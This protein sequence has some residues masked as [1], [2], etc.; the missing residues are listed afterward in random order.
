MTP[1]TTPAEPVLHVRAASL[2]NY[3]AVA[4]EMGLDGPAMLREFGIDARLLQDPESKIAAASVNR[5]LTESA[6][7]SGNEAFGLL[8]AERR[9]FSSFG[10]LSLLLRHEA[11]L[12]EVIRRLQEYSPLLSKVAGFRLEEERDEEA[13]LVVEVAPEVANRQS[14]EMVMALTSDVLGGAMFGGWRPRE[15]YFRHRAPAD[16]SV[17]R[18]VFRAPLRFDAEFNGFALPEG[19]LDRANAHRD[20]GLAVH[21]HRYVELLAQD[22]PPPS[23]DQQVRASI[24][25][26]FGAGGATLERVAAALGMQPRTLQRRLAAQEL[27]FADLVEATR[28]QLACDLLRDSDLPIA[29][30]AARV[31][32][33]TPASFSRW[34][35]RTIGEPPRA[36]RGRAP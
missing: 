30:I 2:I 24:R 5:L 4:R 23:L 6:A 21:A 1:S 17:H 31:G 35:S 26:L 11:S 7:R 9:Q 36:W 32:Y 3:L 27:G 20:A 19:A 34:F 22:L 16:A 15:V 8:L 12:R 25:Q 29:E 13:R 10:P 33:A 28:A 18:R 14:V